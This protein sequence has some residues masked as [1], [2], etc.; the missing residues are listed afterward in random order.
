MGRIPSAGLRLL[1]FSE[2]QAVGQKGEVRFQFGPAY[3]Q[4]KACHKKPRA[5]GGTDLRV[6]PPN[7]LVSS[8]FGQGLLTRP[9]YA[10]AGLPVP[11]PRRVA[12]RPTVSRTA[13]S[14]DPRRTRSRRMMIVAGS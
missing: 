2:L 5:E 9:S 6:P 8:W 12:W 13:G 4:G 10:T 7:I 11:H 14:G 3:P 1:R